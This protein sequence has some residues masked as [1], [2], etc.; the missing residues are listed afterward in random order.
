MQ[1][2]APIPVFRPSYLTDGVEFQGSLT[3]SPANVFYQ[4]VNASIASL[5]RM[6]FQWR[7]VSDQLLVSPVIMLRFK[8]KVQCPQLW[9]QLTSYCSVHGLQTSCAA[10]DSIMNHQTLAT[11][12]QIGVPSIQFADG[13]ALANVAS[14]INLT[15]NGTSLSLNRTNRW[16]RDYTRTQLASDDAAR[17]YKS[18][19]GCYNQND[20]RGVAVP[21][22]Y[23]GGVGARGD[24]GDLRGILAGI[25]QDSGIAE[26]TKNLYAMGVVNSETS[27]EYADTFDL[28]A[29]GA[30]II[31]ISYPVPVPPC[32]PWRGA[33][34]PA[35]CPYKN[36]PLAIPHFSAGGL[37][38][39]FEDFE[40]AFLRYLGTGIASN[41][42]FGTNKN[43]EAHV[44]SN[45]S[46]APVRISYVDK[47][48]ELEIK[49]FRLSHT[50]SLKESYRFNVW[51]AQ[52]FPGPLP[53]STATKPFYN[54][55][56]YDPSNLDSSFFAMPPVGMDFVNAPDNYR[57]R[58]TTILDKP[59][60][61]ISG[62]DEDRIWKCNWDTISL[63]QVP[64]FL[65]ISA[66][67]LSSSYSLFPMHANKNAVTNGKLKG[68]NAMRNQSNNLSIKRLR[69]IVNATS[70][71]IDYSGDDTGFIDMERLY[72]LT[73]ENCNSAYFK[74]GGF[75]AWRDYGCAVLLS[76]AQF[77]PGLQVCDGISYPVSIRVE[78]DLVNRAVKL[79]SLDTG[80]NASGDEAIEFAE[81]AKG[82][83][84]SRDFIRAQGQVTAIFTKVVLSTTE[85]SATTN[86]MNFPLDTSERLMSAAGAMR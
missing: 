66:P 25:V 69:I 85:T 5:S 13:D 3:E 38:F 32:N 14:S 41:A 68:A 15:F 31:Q 1:A 22:L 37:D 67:K 79:C 64:S 35:T 34:L 61:M 65:L 51:Q 84:L 71:A 6:Q 59:G 47:S 30:R 21:A 52:T 36:C 26:R 48:A 33:P 70:G 86:A 57:V 43:Y 78:A 58:T 56:N 53:P 7:S 11:T 49:Y 63:A 60:S 4:R 8:I 72:R 44:G 81:S 40:K 83:Q 73:A 45:I 10:E 80:S 50:R 24:A 46:S 74:E 20:A 82:M 75:R 17:I 28:P 76:S 16:W 2:P 42:A 62:I 9:N 55:E 19:G 29:K 54:I 77:A 23:A 12:K 27:R 18:S 39:L